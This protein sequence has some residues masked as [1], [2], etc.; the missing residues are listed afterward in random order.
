[1]EFLA[2]KTIKVYP[3]R[4]KQGGTP[5]KESPGIANPKSDP[6]WRQTKLVPSRP[7][8]NFNKDP[9]LSKSEVPAKT[10]R[11]PQR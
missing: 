8:E 4:G 7:R 2:N 6:N 5:E 9:S 11:N 10:K 3:N 1:M